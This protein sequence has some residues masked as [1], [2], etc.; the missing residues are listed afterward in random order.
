MRLAFRLT[1]WWHMVQHFWYST[2]GLSSCSLTDSMMIPFRNQI[3]KLILYER[4]KGI[5]HCITK[6]DSITKMSQQ[7]TKYLTCYT[8]LYFQSIHEVVSPIRETLL[9]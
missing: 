5:P 9:L 8:E 6:K 7:L 1:T 4:A 2:R 3:I